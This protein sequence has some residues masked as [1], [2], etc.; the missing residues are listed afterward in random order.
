MKY[1]LIGDQGISMRG[2]RKILEA[3]GHI[4]TGSD[5]KTGGHSASNITPD[6]NFVI[7]NS[8]INLGS[9]GW[10][11]VE[12]AE[13]NKI[14]IIKRSKFIADYMKDKFLIAISGAHGKTTVSSLIGLILI[15]A[16]L[17]PTVLI[18]E[19]VPDM[20]NDVVKIGKSKYFVFEAC[21]YDRS[22]L[23]FQPDIEV[24]TNIDEEHIDTYPKGLPEIIEAFEQYVS[25]I[26]KDGVLVIN[27][28]DI[29]LEKI[30]AKSRQDIKKI[31]FGGDDG[32]YS[33]L[34]YNLKI[35]GEHNKL[36]ALAACAVADYLKINKNIVAK[37]LREFTGAKRR[38]EYKGEVN[39]SLV[40][41]DYGHH[42]TEMRAS[43]EALKQKYPKK[44][45]I[46][47][48]WPHQYKRVKALA[49]Q[50]IDA[51]S[52]SDEVLLKPIF[53]VPGRDK[54]L[55]IASENLAAEINKKGVEAKVFENDSDLVEYLRKI[56]FDDLVILTI[57][58]PPI[59][60]VAEQLVMA[61][62]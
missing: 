19:V 49:E 35:M 17:D 23:D 56:S 33:K 32:S 8:A 38:L 51:L 52:K 54:K 2:V 40:Y 28:K 34:N 45:L 42:P 43:I 57:G 26:K 62:K 55:D 50:F 1:H 21:E 20:N 27:K 37:V 58:I 10:V 25:N 4:V 12:A 6:I 53:F 36:N 44:K 60:K 16:G 18:G 46:T 24:I 30:A 61:E 41:D 3:D 29:N 59:Y 39:N 47:V 13:K 9:E 7:R 11:E 14:P 48:F 5:I 22:F 15:E 31:Y